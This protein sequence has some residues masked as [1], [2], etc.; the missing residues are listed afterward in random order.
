MNALSYAKVAKEGVDCDCGARIV[1][2]S[3]TRW[4]RGTARIG[5]GAIM[6]AADRRPWQTSGPA[7]RRG[8]R[9]R[10]TRGRK[11]R[12][13][14]DADGG[15]PQRGQLSARPFHRCQK[16]P[17]TAGFVVVGRRCDVLARSTAASVEDG[18]ASNHRVG[19][20]WRRPRGHNTAGAAG[21]GGRATGAARRGLRGGQRVE[22]AASPRPELTKD[23]GCGAASAAR[24]M[25][26]LSRLRRT[27]SSRA[28]AAASPAGRAARR[29]GGAR[30]GAG[31]G[32]RRIALRRR[33]A[34]RARRGGARRPRRRRHLAAPRWPGLGAASRAAS[35]AGGRVQRRRGRPPRRQGRTIV[36]VAKRRAGAAAAG[37]A[38]TETAHARA[39][40]EALGLR[41]GRGP[42][43]PAPPR[44]ALVQTARPASP[45][46]ALV[47]T[48]RRP[49]TFLRPAAR[50][51]PPAPPRPALVQT[52]RPGLPAAGACPKRR[53][54]RTSAA[55]GARFAPA[56][57]P[58][59]AL[60]QTARPRTSPRP[61]LVQTARRPRTFRG[62]RLAA[63]A[64][65]SAA[66]ACPN[67]APRT[68]PRPALVQTRAARERFCGRRLA[69]S[70]RR[71]RGR[72]LSK[73]RA[74]S[75][76]RGRRLSKRRAARERGAFRGRRLACSPPAPAAG[77]CPNG[78]FENASAAGA[79]PNGAPPE[80]VSAAG[81]SLA[82]PAGASAAG[83]CPNGAPGLRGR[84]LSK[85]RA[86]R[87]RFCGRRLACSA[88]ASA[89]A[90][91][92]PNGAP[93]NFRGRRLSERRAA[94]ERF[95]GR[96]LA[97]SR[98]RLRGRRLSKRRARV[99]RGR[100]LSKRRAAR[101]RFCAGGHACSRRR[102]SGRRLSKRRARERSAAGACPNGA[103]PGTFLRPAAQA[104]PPAP[105]RPALVQTA[106]PR[107][108]PRPALVQRRAARERFCGRRLACPAG[109][110]AAGACPNGA[111]VFSAA[112][113]CPNG[114]PPENARGR[115]L[116]AP[117][118]ASAAG[119]G[120]N[121][122]LR[123]LRP[124]AGACPNGAPPENVSAAG[125][126]LAPAG[127]SAAGACPNGA[128]EN[129]R[130]RRL[131][132]R[133]AARER[134]CGRRLKF[135]PAGRPRPALSKRRLSR[136]A[137]GGGFKRRAARTFRRPA[138]RLLPAGSSRAGACPNGAPENVSAAG[139]GPNGAPPENVSAA[140]GSFAPAGAPRPALVQT[141]PENA[142]AA[143]ACPNGALHPR[144]GSALS[145]ATAVAIQAA[146]AIDRRRHRPRA[147]V[148]HQ[149][150][151][152]LHADRRDGP[153]GCEGCLQAS[154]DGGA[155]P[156]HTT[157]TD[158]ALN[159][160]IVASRE[161]IAKRFA[162]RLGASA[163]WSWL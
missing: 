147:P 119:A 38:P 2:A 125:G 117:A 102:P 111:G 122:A 20:R 142:S 27:R 4:A 31:R 100:R 154:T 58:R 141:A 91:A 101:E 96:R 108:S 46:P 85:R 132:K 104:P 15:G 126:S 37:E 63:P 79:C 160:L 89:A 115:R 70:R 48:A 161:L 50:L 143:G 156:S 86:A 121:G 157:L 28:T 41:C 145:V 19:R 113:A 98:R 61:A 35:A 128:P 6:A 82:P 134:F 133:R 34:P 94:R 90:G 93:E 43:P 69:C 118:G 49:R 158:L 87:E 36:R 131:S 51:L 55:G 10:L 24:G 12:G 123:R 120:P 75:A 53:A 110:S 40:G 148:E 7:S 140:G 1:M 138:A 144:R 136:P 76:L 107:T 105:P 74:R 155:A 97:C 153:E 77:A 26:L 130:G 56:G 17:S 14:I 92:C 139:A 163:H 11:P 44:P 66:G 88:G 73:R 116:A 22:A 137:A 47:Q 18:A 95:C 80:N 103:P 32:R 146:G 162:K 114:A 9:G 42:P 106:R 78:A 33:G 72:R 81:G 127:A 150:C 5:G 149:R 99:F 135:A 62:R 59:P 57:A 60:V 25:G 39:R 45:R 109:A 54:P 152:L 23:D 52:A 112:G 8:Q 124:A 21:G 65:A 13:R 16:N 159:D 3:P 30:S 71:L 67:G 84:R 64:G 151:A 29:C 83:A 68:S 129:V